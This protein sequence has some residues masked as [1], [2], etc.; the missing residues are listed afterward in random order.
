MARLDYALRWRLEYNGAPLTLKT[1]TQDGS[2]I[3]F[4]MR[5]YTPLQKLMHA[6]C[7]R[8]G[9][10]MSSVRFL[11]D[12][13]RIHE[14]QT[15]EQN[16]HSVRQVIDFEEEDDPQTTPGHGRGATA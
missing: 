15:P 12:G 6:F 8:Q 1:V 5:R 14:A 11:F 7:N 9:V 2:E 16:G 13:N 4:R 3:Y 10:S